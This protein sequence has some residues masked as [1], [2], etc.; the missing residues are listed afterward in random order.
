MKARPLSLALTYLV[1][2]AGAVMFSFPFLWLVSSSIKVDRELYTPTIRLLPQ[3]P[4]P[5]P[6]S[7]YFEDRR[8]TPLSGSAERLEAVLPA[9]QRLVLERIPQRLDVPGQTK[10]QAARAVAEE[11]YASLESRAPA[12]VF[13]GP[14]EGLLAFAERDL[15]AERL[16]ELARRIRRELLIGPVR[17]RSNELQD[18]EVLRELPPTQRWKVTAGGDAVTLADGE[19]GGVKVARLAYDLTRSDRFALTLETALPFDGAELQRVQVRLRPDDTWHGLEA[20]LEVNGRRYTGVRRSVLGNEQWTTITWQFPSPDDYST[21]LR[22]WVVLREA[23]GSDVSGARARLTLTVQR[24]SALEAGYAKVAMNYQRVLD[25]IPLGRYIRVSL[26]LVLANIVLTLLASSLVAYAFARITWPGRDFCFVL[27]LAT[28]MIPGQVTM[29]PH[30]LIWRSVGAYD[31]LTPLW[32]GAAFGNAFFIF[33]MRQFM[34]GI[35]RDLEDAARIDGC[36]FLRIYWHVILPLVKPSLAA[37]AIFTFIGAWND[38]LGPLIYIADQR[39]YPLAFGLYAFS[40]QVQNNPTLTMA[41]SVIM[42]A[43]VIAVFFLAQKYFI[44]G[45]TLTG[46]KG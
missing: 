44:Q 10:E 43:P 46:M 25:Q 30:F 29:I 2:I 22:T 18:V 24:A 41:A 1:L 17:M 3:Q 7:P 4:L 20:V 15:T 31:T 5:R 27:M 13:R 14:V 39:L 12:D 8:L 45:I 35:P 19:D 6:K 32:L 28:M 40:V 38:F 37:I 9:L 16:E 21:K 26:F 33:L 23:G 11:A 34:M 36:G 42:T